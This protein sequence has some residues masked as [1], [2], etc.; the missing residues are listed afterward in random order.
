MVMRGGW[1]AGLAGACV[2]GLMPSVSV[3]TLP[4][5]TACG[6]FCEYRPKEARR[7]KMAVG[8]RMRVQLAMALKLVRLE[9]MLPPAAGPGTVELRYSLPSWKVTTV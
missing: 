1:L 2:I 8:E 3:V 9:P 6:I 5:V 4:S 7:S